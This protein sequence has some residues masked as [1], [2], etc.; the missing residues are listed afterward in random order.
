MDE[1]LIL[2]GDGLLGSCFWLGKKVGRKDADL[3]NYQETYELI[4]KHNPLWVINCAGKV[5]GVKANIENKF[6]FF[7]INTLINLNVIK[8]CMELKVPNLI[9]FLSTC[10]FPDSYS[11][12]GNLVESHLHLGEPHESNYAYAYSKRMTDVLS[13]VAREKGFNYQCI[14]P[15]NLYGYNDNYDLNN[16]HVIPALIRKVGDGIIQAKK[17]S[18]NVVDFEVWGTGNPIRQFLFANDIV[19]AVL[20]II[21]EDIRFGNIIISDE[22]S[23]SIKE[24]V[25]IIISIYRELLNNEFDFLR[26]FNSSKPDGQYKKTTDTSKFQILIDTPITDLKVGLKLVIAEYWKSIN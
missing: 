20:K 19:S 18:S 17:D 5:G 2:G 23:Y 13:Q 25:D 9:S 11:L 22:K 12:K 16:S 3:T 24:V 10:I 8:A 6:E 21:D 14:I 7:E 4:K 26:T 15:T 1:I